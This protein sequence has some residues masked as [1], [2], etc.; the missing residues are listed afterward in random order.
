MTDP[1]VLNEPAVARRLG[2]SPFTLRAWRRQGRGPAYM[3][4]GRAVRYRIADVAAFEQNVLKIGLNSG[5]DSSQNPM[6]SS[7][8]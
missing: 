5:V 4:L 8:S 6:L 1:I 2:V 7:V 3:K